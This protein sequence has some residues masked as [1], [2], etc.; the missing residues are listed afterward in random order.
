MMDPHF[1]VQDGDTNVPNVRLKQKGFLDISDAST[2][3]D[4]A[5]H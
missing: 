1:W 4:V 3:M 2:A 5:D